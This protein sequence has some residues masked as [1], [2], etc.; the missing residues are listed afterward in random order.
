[1]ATS[2]P[3]AEELAEQVDVWYRTGEWAQQWHTLTRCVIALDRIGQPA[4]AAEVL[5]SIEGTARSGRRR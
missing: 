2:S 1:M 4:V 5:G 3:V